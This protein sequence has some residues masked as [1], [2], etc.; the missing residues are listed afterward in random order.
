MSR[1]GK[2]FRVA[3]NI[4]TGKKVMRKRIQTGILTLM[5]LI[6]PKAKARKVQAVVKKMK[7]KTILN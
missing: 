5:N 1:V 6:Y 7:K 3:S 4:V 2:V